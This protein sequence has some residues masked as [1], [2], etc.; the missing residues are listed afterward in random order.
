MTPP[1]RPLYVV[2]QW[3]SAHETADARKCA[4][5]LRWVAVPTRHDGLGFRRVAAHREQ[6]AIF[7]AWILLLQV[8]ARRPQGQRGVLAGEDGPL[9]AE[10]L[11]VMT[12]FPQAAFDVALEFLASPRVGWLTRFDPDA[13][14]RYPDASGYRPGSSGSLSDASASA[15]ARPATPRDRGTAEVPP[16]DLPERPAQRTSRHRPRA[17]DPEPSGH[18]AAVDSQPPASGR[19]PDT[20]GSV[21]T[22]PG[23]F[24]LQ[25]RTGQ[26]R[27][28]QEPPELTLRPP[29]GDQRAEKRL[30][31]RRQTPVSD[32]PPTVDEFVAHGATLSTPMTAAEARRAWNYYASIGWRVGRNGAP[33]VD[34]RAALANWAARSGQAQITHG[35]RSDWNTPPTGPVPG[36]VDELLAAAPAAD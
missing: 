11:A 4:T 18:Q 15:P 9:D 7:A 5:A 14:G 35:N 12:G 10:D 34:W 16:E 29:A 26:D 19:H 32:A 17:S 25:D 33:M 20:P 3:A 2:T 27:T 21:R 23:S 28:E 24:R 1:P 13:S 30:R 6:C 31:R 36:G 22:S 8:A